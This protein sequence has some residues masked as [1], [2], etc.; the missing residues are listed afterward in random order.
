M[1]RDNMMFW[2]RICCP[3]Q[4]TIPFWV[5]FL[6]FFL[7]EIVVLTTS[8]IV[9]PSTMK[10]NSPL[11][12]SGLPAILRI[13][14]WGA[15]IKLSHM[16]SQRH[17]VWKVSFGLQRFDSILQKLD[18]RL[19]NEEMNYWVIVW[20]IELL[21]GT[22]CLN[23]TGIIFGGMIFNYGTLILLI[24]LMNIANLPYTIFLIWFIVGE[25]CVW[26]RIKMLSTLLQNGRQ[27]ALTSDRKDH[28]RYRKLA[29]EISILHYEL[30][31]VVQNIN[32]V[33]GVQLMMSLCA[34]T[35]LSIFAL[36]SYYRATV[37]DRDLETHFCQ[38]MISWVIYNSATVWPA[39]LFGALVY[40]GANRFGKEV[41]AFLR[42]AEDERAQ[43]QFFTLAQQL[44]HRS[45][46][47][48]T[49]LF[50]VNWPV[51]ASVIGYIATYI[52]ILIQFDSKA[53]EIN[54]INNLPETNPNHTTFPEPFANQTVY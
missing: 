9:I 36:F 11:L 26:Y 1:W 10:T 34:Y 32:S 22:I 24:V 54:G 14:S 28:T 37:V 7:L 19:H 17:R 44:D 30:S 43:N 2:E 4:S 5:M 45:I 21:L 23:A 52:V 50:F 41:H 39:I 15:I 48:K 49:G 12:D 8:L 13:S 18:F 40:G 16:F 53:R 20:T 51:F 33:F 42:Q 6:S 31:T 25:L 3:K 29:M 46:A 27:A 47:I 38:L 35:I